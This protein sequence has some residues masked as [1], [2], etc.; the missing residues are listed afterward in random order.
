M[1]IESIGRQTLKADKIILWLDKNE[2]TENNLPFR[3]RR[4]ESR[5][6]SIRYCENFKSYKKIIP[7][8]LEFK[9]SNVVTIDD[10]IV[11]KPSLIEELV[12]EHLFY[13]NSIIGHRC[14]EITRGKDGN[15]LPYIKWKHDTK[16]NIENRDIFITTGGGTLFPPNAI[17]S[18]F[19]NYELISSLCPNADD[20]WVKG[21]SI[22]SNVE[23][24]KVSNESEFSC[25]NYFLDS[26][27]DELSLSNFYK[28]GNDIQIAEFSKHFKIKI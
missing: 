12:K 25:E 26:N 16:S 8:L 19:L 18:E 2:F 23:C 17:A 4:M 10:D 5:G 22:I 6:L 11:Y 13:P 21:V 1:A 20:V 9:N 27:G 14:H 3:L 28:N 7:A 15:I 24:R